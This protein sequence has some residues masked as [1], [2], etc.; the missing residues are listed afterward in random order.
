MNNKATKS[1]MVIFRSK[2]KKIHIR[3]KFDRQTV[4]LT[5]AQIASL[6]GTERPAI[7]KHLNNIFKSSE[8]NKNSVCSKMEHTA[9]DGKRYQTQ[10]YNLDAIISVGYRVNSLRATQFRIWATRIL[11][12]YLVRG[13]A[14]NRKRL[15]E[16][17]DK[18]KELQQTIEFLQSKSSIPVLQVQAEEILSIIKSYAG[19]MTL[20]FQYDKGRVLRYK[21]RKSRFVLTYDNACSLV[22]KM[23]WDLSRK[24]EATNLFGKEVNNKLMSI[25]GAVYQTFD[26]KDLYPT[27]EEKASNLLYLIIKDHPFVDGNKRIAS[28][29]FLYYLNKNAFLFKKNGEPKIPDTTMVALALLIA[30]SEPKEKDIMINIITNLLKA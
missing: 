12:D 17:Q 16:Q 26:K 2:D 28:L 11:K 19:A 8:L 10:F 1:N 22:E 4:W 14:L 25:I 20:L 6:F 3:V 29:L 23:R 21:T 18:F 5:Q 27:I 13:Y 9:L 7:T 15:L 30:I 24:N